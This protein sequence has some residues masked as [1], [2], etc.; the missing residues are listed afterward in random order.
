MSGLGFIEN[1]PFKNSVNKEYLYSE[2]LRLKNYLTALKENSFLDKAQEF[3]LQKC[4]EV[5]DRHLNKNNINSSL[6]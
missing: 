2:A 6:N 5:I 4:N 3:L 1:D